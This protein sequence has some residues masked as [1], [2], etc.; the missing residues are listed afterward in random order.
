MVRILSLSLFLSGAFA[1]SFSSSEP[2]V[3]PSTKAAA[4]KREKPATPRKPVLRNARFR[5][6]LASLTEA[7][8]EKLHQ[9][10]VAA[11]AKVRK[12]DETAEPTKAKPWKCR[13]GTFHELEGPSGPALFRVFERFSS[14]ECGDDE[15]E[16]EKWEANL[17]VTS[18]ARVEDRA[19]GGKFPLLLAAIDR[20]YVEGEWKESF[21]AFYS[22]SSAKGEEGGF[23]HDEAWLAEHLP[24]GWTVKG[25][26]PVFSERWAVS[27]AMV[28]GEKITF[29]AESIRCRGEDEPVG[30]ELIF[31]TNKRAAGHTPN[32]PKD[33]VVTDKLETFA[34]ALVEELGELAGGRGAT[35][36]AAKTCAE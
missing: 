6:P 7:D 36:E 4:K 32:T 11:H 19:G 35:L 31:R 17:R 1:C 24:A 5:I 22:L 26:S 2:T 21:G 10:V 23:P 20:D 30:A 12:E 9:A 16:V 27:Q 18:E 15:A 14:P 29:E 33:V 28:A 8:V 34:A 3:E 25:S 13:R